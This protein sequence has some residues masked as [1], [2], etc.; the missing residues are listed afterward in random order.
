MRLF[1][2]AELPDEIKKNIAKLIGELKT[3]DAAVKWVEANNLH[4]T[5]KFMGNVADKE[6]DKWIDW[7]KKKVGGSGGGFRLKLEGM[8][9]F[10][11]GKHPRVVWVGGSNG[12]KNLRT[13]A[14]ALEEAEFVSHVTIGR[15]KEHKGVDK[16]KGK[17]VGYKD[18]KFG[19]AKIN[20][21]FIMKSTLTPKGPVYEKIK[22]VML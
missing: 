22:E 5:L 3:T 1:I 6:I 4:L 17:I 21:I 9:T 18:A 14:E 7:T 10:P 15:I 13:T 19:E 2:A 8:G 12:S 20:S 16:L 11:E